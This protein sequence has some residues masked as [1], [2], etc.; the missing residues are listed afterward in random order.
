[1]FIILNNMSYDLNDIG[2]H[3]WGESQIP[4]KSLIVMINNKPKNNFKFVKVLKL[5]E[6]NNYVTHFDV[7]YSKG[8]VNRIA[9]VMLNIV[10][11]KSIAQ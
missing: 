8:D 5:N 10:T 6:L 3:H 7:I 4:L 11:D 2:I 1:M 9:E